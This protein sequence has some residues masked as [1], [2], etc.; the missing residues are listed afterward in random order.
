[1]VLQIWYRIFDIGLYPLGL[2][3]IYK[4]SYESV[5]KFTIADKITLLQKTT[6]VF[7]VYIVDCV[8]VQ[9]RQFTLVSSMGR[10]VCWQDVGWFT[11]NDP[12]L[13][14]ITYTVLKQSVDHHDH[15]WHYQNIID[16]RRHGRCR[17]RYKVRQ[18]RLCITRV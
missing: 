5:S 17:F 9:S 2:N 18:S 3:W 11:G 7:A 12:V 1:M 6:T 4:S 10:Q 13:Y 16:I 14:Q 8:I 15:R